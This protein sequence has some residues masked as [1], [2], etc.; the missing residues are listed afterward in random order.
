MSEV[1]NVNEML[2][3]SIQTRKEAGANKQLSAK[4]V[5]SGEAS[6]I[7]EEVNLQ[8]KSSRAGGVFD[9]IYEGY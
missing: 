1:V 7:K 8:R 3:Q 2:V 6:L 9:G 4:K 5:D